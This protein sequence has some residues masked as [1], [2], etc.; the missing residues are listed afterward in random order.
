M[1]RIIFSSV[2]SKMALNERIMKQQCQSMSIN[3]SRAS[4]PSRPSVPETISQRPA[5]A[6]PV[7]FS[8]D[9]KR[10]QHINNIRNAPV[11]AQIKLVI[12]LLFKV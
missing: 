2:H 8:D 3:S 10:L 6:A 11:G 12:D 9:T 7:K 5:L 1:V 4:G